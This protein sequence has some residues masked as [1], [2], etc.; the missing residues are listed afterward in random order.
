VVDWPGAGSEQIGESLVTEKEAFMPRFL[1]QATFNQEAAKRLIEDGGTKRAFAVQELLIQHEARLENLYF[2]PQY[3]GPDAFAIVEVSVG[4]A[5]ALGAMA[6]AGRTT[7]ITLT[8]RR[9]FTPEE[10][11]K[12]AEKSKGIPVPGK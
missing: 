9:I 8:A 10:M 12:V 4:G 5:D 7:G 11:D 3:D 2:S 6:L 1:L